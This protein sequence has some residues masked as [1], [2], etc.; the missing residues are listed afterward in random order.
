MKLLNKMIEYPDYKE[1]FP[2]MMA[3]EVLADLGESVM[4]INEEG[5]VLVIK[6]SKFRLM[7]A[8]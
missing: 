1:F 8:A 3:A 2:K 4:C 5:A 7:R 6:K